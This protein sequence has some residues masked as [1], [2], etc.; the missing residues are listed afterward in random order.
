MLPRP[1]LLLITDRAQV[2]GGGLEGVIAAACAAGCRWVSLR[3]KDLPPAEQIALFTRL[4]EV[5]RRFNARL[6]LHGTAA[7]AQ[8]AQADGVH[9]PDGADAVSARALLG[10][11]ALIGQSYHKPPTSTEATGAV[12]YLTASPIFLTRSKPGYGPAL[13][14]P[15]LSAFVAATP[16]P[17][18]AL[19]GVTADT[20]ASCHA[21]GAHGIAVMG[22]VMRAAVPDE[23]VAALIR[24]LPPTSLS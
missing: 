23:T 18:I 5:T 13:G 20:A 1:P 9:L 17:I 6:T 22:E 24:A 12:D 15:G 21:A 3:E 4:R 11:Q 10:P 14:L 16:T 2:P 7:L 19:G 8:A